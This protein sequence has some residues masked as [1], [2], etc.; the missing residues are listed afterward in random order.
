MNALGACK[1]S[2]RSVRRQRATRAQ[3]L[4]C[5][6]EALRAHRFEQVIHRSELESLHRVLIV[7]GDEDHR[8]RCRQAGEVAGKLDAVHHRHAD[9]GEHHVGT[10]VLQQTQ[11]LDAVCGHAHDRAR[12]RGRNVAEEVAQA[13]A[14]RRLVIDDQHAQGLA[15]CARL[16]RCAHRVSVSKGRRIRTR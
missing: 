15:P 16:A 11:R 5:S 7:G 14:R 13:A 1:G 3:A 8:R 6:L 10:S 12:L 4:E 2:E 9:V